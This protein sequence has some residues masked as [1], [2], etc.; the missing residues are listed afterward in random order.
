MLNRGIDILA[1]IS[2]AIAAGLHC[3]ALVLDGSP[4]TGLLAAVLVVVL[5]FIVSGV[6]RPATRLL[7]GLVLL[8]AAFPALGRM[9]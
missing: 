9:H 1:T 4:A 8:L 6:M 5:G 2:F 7:L 3:W